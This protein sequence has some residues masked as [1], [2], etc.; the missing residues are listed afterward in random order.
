MTF[1]ITWAILSALAFRQIRRRIKSEPRY[2]K[3]HPLWFAL[4]VLALTSAPAGLI[5]WV[6]T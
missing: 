5:A 6:L 4:T 1:L 2:D 3:P